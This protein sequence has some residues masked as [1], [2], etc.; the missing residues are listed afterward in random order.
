MLKRIGA[1]ESGEFKAVASGTLPSGKP[2]VV[3]ADGTVSV[4]APTTVS[5]ATGSSTSFTSE[6]ILGGTHGVV[7]CFDSASN[8]VVIAY[9]STD[10]SWDAYA[11]VGTVSGTSISFGTPV[12]FETNT[13]VDLGDVV[14]FDSSNNKVVISYKDD[15]YSRSS[16]TGHM[17]LHPRCWIGGGT[18][19]DTSSTLPTGSR[20][21]ISRS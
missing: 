15:G 5:G 4:V 6:T 18:P 17:G 21:A 14:V 19:E 13:T 16:R 3:N 8:K 11:I 20:C 7:G 12:A 1:E 10:G 2:V 9:N